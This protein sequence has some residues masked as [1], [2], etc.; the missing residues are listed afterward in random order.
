MSIPHFAVASTFS[1]RFFAVLAEADRTAKAFGARLSVL[2][3][4]ERTDEKNHSFQEAFANLGRENVDIYWC[5]GD[6]PSE[7]LIAAVA[8]ER[9]D[10]FIAGTIARPSDPRNFTG[11]IVRELF[12]RTPCDLLLIPDPQEKPPSELNACLLL[13]AH[14]PRWQAVRDKL[15]TLQPSKISI[16]AADS[17]LTRARA[18]LLGTKAEGT[19]L[20]EICEQLTEITPEVELLRI[21]SNTGFLMCEVVQE[22]APDFLFVE[23]SWKDGQRVLQPHL[24]WLEQVIPSRLFLFSQRLLS[25]TGDYSLQSV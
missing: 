13:E 10:L 7:A 17:P 21:Q 20:D 8:R 23:S 24:G 14:S 22:M 2:H 9:F 5:E 18:A 1:P 19:S 3:A 12:A 4:G 6:S 15:K 25:P 11:T 16:L